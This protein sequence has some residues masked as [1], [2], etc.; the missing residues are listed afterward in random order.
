MSSKINI[1]WFPGHMTKARR[2]IQDK[3][4]MVDMVIELRDARVPA[5]SA[6]PLIKDIIGSKP[7][8]IVLTKADLAD[9]KET[10]KWIK[11]FNDEQNRVI[12]V[13]ALETGAVKAVVN[14]CIELMQPMIERQKRRGIKPRP[15][16]CMVC[17]IP[18]VGKST[19]INQIAKKKVAATGN[20]PGVTKSLQWIKSGKQIELLDTPGVL[21][22]KFDDE[23]VG[24]RLAV[25]GAIK[26]QILPLEEVA[27]YAI[28]YLIDACPQSLSERY[29]VAINNNEHE[30][31]VAIGKQKGILI[32][33]GEVDIKR[34]LVLF[35]KDIR[36]CKFG[37]LTWERCDE[38]H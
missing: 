22:P 5:A 15:I 9:E 20:R 24:L 11:Y 35:M 30:M 2:D 27:Y 4:K 13:D 28:R 16:R 31:L 17:G 34:T 33:G 36:E 37:R 10:L 19:L 21:W 38:V 6:N 29:Q 32:H 18:N 8:L 12:A 14:N 23:Q 7:R 25:T 1:Q 26:D 3:L